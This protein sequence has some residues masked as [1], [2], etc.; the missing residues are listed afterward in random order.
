MRLR[1]CVG[2]TRMRQKMTEGDGLAGRSPSVNRLPLRPHTKSTSR[3]LTLLALD[4]WVAARLR[5]FKGYEF[6][7]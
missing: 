1:A 7:D 5:G 4:E 2:G 3:A 6:G